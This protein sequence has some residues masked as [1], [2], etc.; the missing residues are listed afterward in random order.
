MRRQFAGRPKTFLFA[1]GAVEK[2]AAWPVARA[3]LKI[4]AERVLFYWIVLG[5]LVKVLATFPAM[6]HIPLEVSA[7]ALR[8]IR[9]VSRVRVQSARHPRS[10]PCSITVQLFLQLFHR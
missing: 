2:L 8:G 3:V 4:V 5:T 6:T 1:L 9:D 7:D 10:V